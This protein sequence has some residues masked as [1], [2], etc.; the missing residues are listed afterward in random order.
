MLHVFVTQASFRV[1]PRRPF[2]MQRQHIALHLGPFIETEDRCFHDREAAMSHPFRK[3]PRPVGARGLRAVGRRIVFLTLLQVQRP[4]TSDSQPRHR[5]RAPGTRLRSPLAHRAAAYSPRSVRLIRNASSLG[6]L[7]A[8]LRLRRKW[9]RARSESASPHREDGAEGACR[10][11]FL[12]V[13]T[14]RHS[15]ERIRLRVR[16]RRTRACTS[17]ARTSRGRRLAVR[18]R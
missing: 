16:A 3:S 7:Y 6:N 17:C 2:L 1:L 13:P 9:L 5:Q 4:T 10:E 18:P 15:A 14:P 8:G 12:S 11:L